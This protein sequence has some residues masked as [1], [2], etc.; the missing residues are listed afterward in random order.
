MAYKGGDV[1]VSTVGLDDLVKELERLE[2][3]SDVV[4]FCEDTVYAGVNVMADYM[5]SQLKNLKTQSKENHR[6]D[7]R[8]AYDIEKQALLDSLGYT[9]VK[10]FGSN[11]AYFDS[12]VG[13]D[14]YTPYK[15]PD[16]AKRQYRSNQMIANSINRGTSFM[17][18]QPFISRAKRAG[19]TKVIEAMRAELEKYIKS[20]TH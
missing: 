5:R 18:A 10:Q 14:G 17:I 15:R 2:S 16:L 3:P 19:Q 7:K 1:R 20:R 12:N 4:M 8:Y 13:F 6:K 9:P 11:L